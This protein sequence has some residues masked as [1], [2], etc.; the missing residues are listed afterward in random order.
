MLVALHPILEG[1]LCWYPRAALASC[2][3]CPQHLRTFCYN[4]IKRGGFLAEVFAGSAHYPA[5]HCPSLRIWN[6]PYQSDCY[7][8]TVRTVPSLNDLPHSTMMS[9]TVVSWSKRLLGVLYTL[10][11]TFH[12][13]LTLYSDV[14][15]CGVLG[16]LFCWLCIVPH[17]VQ[18]IR[19]MYSQKL[20]CAALFSV[21]TSIYLWYKSLTDTWM[22]N[23]GDRIL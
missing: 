8:W 20:N 17:T 7:L 23:L 2:A 22:W 18:K 11:S 13:T 15:Y 6:C 19:F 4:S 21:P 14:E 5:L 3:L 16:E 12:W 1:I 9:N 10:Y